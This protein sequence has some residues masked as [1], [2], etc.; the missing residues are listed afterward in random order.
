MIGP[1]AQSSELPVFSNIYYLAELSLGIGFHGGNCCHEILVM[2][3]LS[4]FLDF[5]IIF[6]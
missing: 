2:K 1:Q 6:L 4:L 3:Q 5:Y